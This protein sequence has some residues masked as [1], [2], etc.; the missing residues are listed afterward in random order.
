MDPRRE[1]ESTLIN[2]GIINHVTLA[3]DMSES[4][5]RSRSQVITVTD[6]LIAH[7]A[8]MS[9]DLQQETRVTIY[10]FN[11]NV[12]CVVYDKDV[13]R[14]PSL[15]DHYQPARM[16]ALIDA[17]IQAIE[18]LKL[19]PTKY[20]DHGFLIYALTD[21]QENRSHKT[22]SALSRLIGSLGQEWTLA[23]LVPDA[24]GVK[25]AQSF[26][27]PKGNI[28][29]WDVNSSTGV[30]EVGETVKMSAGGYM[31]MRAT[32]QS[33]TRTLFSTDPTA[34]NAATIQAAGLKPLDKNTYSIIPV[35]RARGDRNQGVLNRDNKR[36]WEISDFVRHAGLTFEA[37][38]AFYLLDKKELIQAD[39]QLAIVEKATNKV[40]VGDGVRAMVG[41]PDANK[42][43]APDF[44]PEY[45][46]YVQSK[47]TN[48]HLFPGNKILVLK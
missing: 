12:E 16:T 14:L 1:E 48:R 13:L 26:G 36:V 2:Q 35:P 20:G 34:V 7:L 18:D 47:S 29:I 43:V 9:Q 22:A 21:G 41:L 11:D 3:I 25:Y 19:T 27:F 44:N 37:G 8:K 33:G 17:T 23:C 10:L 32:G 4:M 30:E 42:S 15:R 40:F 31:A 24:I 28:A 5:S 6:G 39:K 46:I 45:D 38:K